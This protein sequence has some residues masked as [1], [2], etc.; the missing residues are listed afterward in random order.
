MC[1]INIALLKTSLFSPN[2]TFQIGTNWPK[3]IFLV[4][5]SDLLLLL[6][7]LFFTLSKCY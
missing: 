7:L 5:F 4:L 6:L 3:L 2:G 1:I